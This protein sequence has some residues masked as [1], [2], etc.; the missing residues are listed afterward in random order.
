[1]LTILLSKLT[2]LK[3]K[4]FYKSRFNVLSTQFSTFKVKTLLVVHLRSNYTLH[5]AESYVMLLFR[6]PVCHVL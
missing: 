4:Y 6:L 3:R 2:V 1:M 5:S